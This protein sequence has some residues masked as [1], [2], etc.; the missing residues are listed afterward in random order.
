MSNKKTKIGFSQSLYW[1]GF[2]YAPM[3]V[4]V[5]ISRGLFCF[6][7]VG[8]ADKTMTESK[9]RILSALKNCNFELPQRK[10]ERVIVSLLP[11]NKKKAGTYAD[12]AI[13]FSYL[14]GSRQLQHILPDQNICCIGEI[15]L[16][17]TV[18]VKQDIVHMF[19]AGIQA[20]M[21]KFIVPKNSS[22]HLNLLPEIE[23][24]EIESLSDLKNPLVFIPSNLLKNGPINPLGAKPQK[25]IDKKLFQVDTLRGLD[26]Q[27]RAFMIGL[28]GNHHMLFS[29]LPGCGKSALADC[30]DE[31]LDPLTS[32][33]AIETYA[34]HQAVKMTQLTEVAGFSF[35]RPKRRPHP[36]IMIAGLMGEGGNKPGE[37]SLAH[38]GIIILNEICESPKQTIESL[39]DPMENQRLLIH[40]HGVGLEFKLHTIFIATTNLCPCGKI[41]VHMFTDEKIA[42]TKENKTMVCACTV[43]QIQRYQRKISEPLLDR[44]PIICT[45]SYASLQNNKISKQVALQTAL[46]NT[47]QTTSQIILQTTLLD[48]KTDKKEISGQY[49]KTKIAKARE[50]QRERNPPGTGDSNKKYNSQL[51]VEDIDM[52]GIS[53][54]ARLDILKL[55]E[56]FDFSNRKI[57]HIM[58]VARTIADIEEKPDIETNHL[59][60]ATSYVKTR[61]F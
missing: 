35:T 3:N 11:S 60:E 57:G 25:H 36:S 39:R 15:R 42:V 26:Y 53:Q 51:S 43:F 49:M 28:A 27:K 37:L 31:L 20:G 22:H 44:F 10:N 9:Y 21:K 50:I 32:T 18:M 14:V 2:S 19:H 61:P 40:K 45:F 7:I 5:D 48:T 52:L 1:S 6:N 41:P 56:T 23:I 33:E 46:P 17:G 16:D 8:L 4:E 47:P 29:G 38:N 12:L 54:E 24:F 34:I 58:R 55:K 59:L 30:A 13:A